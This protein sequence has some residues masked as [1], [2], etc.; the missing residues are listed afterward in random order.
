M[1]EQTVTAT[2]PLKLIAAV[3]LPPLGV[4]MEVG[5]TGQFW[6]NVLLTLFFWVPGMIHAFY[7]I[8]TR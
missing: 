6:L 8:L 5:L 3:L 1:K 7:I 2:D 4:A